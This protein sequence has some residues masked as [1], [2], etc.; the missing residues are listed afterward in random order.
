MGWVVL[1][2]WVLLAAGL[3]DWVP[4]RMGIA[5]H[6][7][8]LWVAVV[9]YLAARGRG[10]SAVGWGMLVGLLR[11]AQSLD[12]LGTHGFTLGAVGLL[13]CEGRSDRGRLDG[14]SRAVCLVAG[15]LAACW[16]GLLRSLPLGGSVSLAAVLDAFPT[17]LWTLV[18]S[19]P[20]F[21][22]LD[23]FGALDDLAG[24]R[25]GLPA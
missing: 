8:D 16:L 15:T 12:P 11:D 17:A 22:T 9:I 23:R 13:F 21:A 14:V 6:A 10:Y 24:R 20:L 19:L 18:A 3:P 2:L 7:P 5:A 4:E 25:R 1:L